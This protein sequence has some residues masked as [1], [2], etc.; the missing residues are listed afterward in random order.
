[1]VQS[2]PALHSIPSSD[3]DEE[4]ALEQAV[5]R[6]R[7]EIIACESAVKLG[8]DPEAVHLQRVAARRLRSLLGSSG[9]LSSDPERA[10]RLSEELRWLARALGKVRDRDVLIAYLLDELVSLDEAGAF[11]AV[12][13]L[14]D[15]ERQEGRA[16]LR[17]VL[18]SARYRNLLHELAQP[19]RLREGEDLR[20]PAITEY[21]R[22]REA[23]EQL[24]DDPA[25]LE[26][27]E[28]RIQVKRARYAAEAA[29][30]S[31]RYVERARALQ[32]ILGE[33]QDAVV[34]ADTL[35]ELAHQH[36]A[37]TE[38]VLAC[39]RLVERER[40]AAQA[41]RAAFH[42]EWSRVDS[43]RYTGWLHG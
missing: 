17:D 18:D 10:H 36:P 37:D 8:A 32:D 42:A 1:M 12:L 26:L 35:L 19:P 31:P 34:T 2:P 4:D 20:S 30:A 13:E 24:D 15:C 22:L 5:R 14:L 21:Q 7:E 6:Y 11:G 27:H 9:P 25:D 41:A 33:H 40:T 23:V 28:V 3:S 43:P 39:G 16:K 29:G 38:L